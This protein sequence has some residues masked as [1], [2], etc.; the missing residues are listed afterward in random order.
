MRSTS[1]FSAVS[2]MIG[3]L[4][5]LCP[6]VAAKIEARAVGQHHVEHDQIDLMRGE[7]LGSSRQLAASDTRKPW[8]SI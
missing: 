4:G 2:R 5:T 7:P 6:Q 1:S 8:L 3:T